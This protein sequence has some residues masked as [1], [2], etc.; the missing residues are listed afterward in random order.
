MEA[1]SLS[2]PKQTI[3]YHAVQLKHN[4]YPYP[5]REVFLHSF[6]EFLVEFSVCVLTIRDTI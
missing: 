1:L 6:F 3:V 2:E 5:L 4:G